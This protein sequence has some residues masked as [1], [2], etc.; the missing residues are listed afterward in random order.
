M[1]IELFQGSLELV[2]NSKG[3]TFEDK[4]D[5]VVN[6]GGPTDIGVKYLG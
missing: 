5:Q 2:R 3:S 1:I 6:P 4:I